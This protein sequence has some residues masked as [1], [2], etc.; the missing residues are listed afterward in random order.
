MGGA[1]LRTGLD[2]IGARLR[3]GGVVLL[4]SVVSVVLGLL[5]RA[6]LVGCGEMAGTERNESPGMGHGGTVGQHWFLALALPLVI[7]IGFYH[8]QRSFCPAA[9]EQSRRG[10]ERHGGETRERLAAASLPV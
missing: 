9:L 7:R 2:S 5:G 8:S 10:V 4:V 1:D 6:G 3:C